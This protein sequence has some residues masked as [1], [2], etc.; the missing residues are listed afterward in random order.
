MLRIIRLPCVARH[1]LLMRLSFLDQL[2][3]SW[4][5]PSFARYNLGCLFSVSV[6]LLFLSPSSVVRCFIPSIYLSANFVCFLLCLTLASTSSPFLCF[7]LFIHFLSS[8]CSFF[9]SLLFLCLL[10]YISSFSLPPSLSPAY[11]SLPYE[12]VLSLCH[13]TTERRYRSLFLL[14][15]PLSF[16][17]TPTPLFSP[18]STFFP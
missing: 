15:T 11:L 16:S 14:L 17:L 8:V 10:L 7:S 4:I 3:S 18:S 9:L 6:P 1:S 12:H 2:T 5:P 13:H